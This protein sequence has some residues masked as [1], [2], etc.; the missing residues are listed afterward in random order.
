MKSKRKL[1]KGFLL[2]VALLGILLVSIVVGLINPGINGKAYKIES[3]DI[4][5]NERN[6]LIVE[7][8]VKQYNSNYSYFVA[9]SD[10]DNNRWSSQMTYNNGI[11][12]AEDQF[13]ISSLT[14]VSLKVINGDESRE[15]KFAELTFLS[16]DYVDFADLIGRAKRNEKVEQ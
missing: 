3:Y 4:Y 9:Y 2:F 16:S 13:S 7:I 10:Q 14:N 5:V 8:K 6:K 12:S 15:V 11:L 1:R